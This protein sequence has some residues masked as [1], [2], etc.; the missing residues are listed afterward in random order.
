MRFDRRRRR[1][2]FA[3]LLA[4][5]GAALHAQ[6][7]YRTFGPAVEAGVTHLTFSGADFTRHDDFNTDQNHRVDPALGFH[8]SGVFSARPRLL[9]AVGV[10]NTSH[11]TDYA[12]DNLHVLQFY[13]EPRFMI[14]EAGRAT[15]YAFAH[16]SVLHATQQ[17]SL[18]DSNNTLVSGNATQTGS[19]FGGGLGVQ[20]AIRPHVYGLVV[21]QYNTELLGDIDFDGTHVADSSDRGSGLLIRA[22]IGVNLTGWETALK[23][24][25][26]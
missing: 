21:A 19:A 11:K 10:E 15:G 22:G 24:F 14:A 6:E 1:F 20:V 8:L 7:P 13:V 26:R 9:L 3:A 17:I 16:L 23:S 25:G 5:G 18:F 4:G 2:L 12:S